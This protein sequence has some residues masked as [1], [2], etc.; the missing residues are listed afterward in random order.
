[1]FGRE[2]VYTI[3]PEVFFV[4]FSLL[5]SNQKIDFGNSYKNIWVHVCT[6]FHYVKAA[7]PGIFH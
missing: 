3:Q 7:N 1:M 5:L 2:N 4:F 6:A